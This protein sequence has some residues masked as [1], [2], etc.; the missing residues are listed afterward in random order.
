MTGLL[1]SKRNQLSRTS[2]RLS[3]IAVLAACISLWLAVESI[4]FEPASA[5]AATP[6]VQPFSNLTS[7]F[8]SATGSV[9]RP[10]G[11]PLAST[12]LAIPGTSPVLPQ[13]GVNMSFGN[14]NCFIASKPGAVFDGG[15][16]SGNSS[17][18]CGAR[19]TTSIVRPATSTSSSVGLSGIPL[20]STELGGAGLSPALS[21]PLPTSSPI[22]SSPPAEAM[23]CPMD[24]ATTTTTAP[25]GC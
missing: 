17:T 11:I 19:G 21:L 23:P 2:G 6:G 8:G 18:G 10:A 15:G 25:S 4:S 14:E 7:P 1:R 16:L 5:Q 20:G 3:P 13:S 22:D 9:V 12:E 24:G